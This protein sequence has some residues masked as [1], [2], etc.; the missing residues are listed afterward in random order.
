VNIVEDSTISTETLYLLSLLSRGLYDI[1]LPL[2][3]QGHKID[4]DTKPAIAQVW[5][6][7]ATLQFQAPNESIARPIKSDHF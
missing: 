5:T 4:L 6:S 7:G 1:A 3:L 2:Y